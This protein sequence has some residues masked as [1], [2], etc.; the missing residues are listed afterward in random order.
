MAIRTLSAI[1]NL[2]R[3][4]TASKAGII[5][6]PPVP[7]PDVPDTPGLYDP[8]YVYNLYDISGDEPVLYQANVN[9]NTY[10][11]NHYINTYSL[12][13]RD[14]DFKAR[15]SMGLCISNAGQLFCIIPTV[16]DGE[17]VSVDN[18]PRLVDANTDWTYVS[19]FSTRGLAIRDGHVYYINYDSDEDEFNLA[20]VGTGFPDYVQASIGFMTPSFIRRSAS[21]YWST[22]NQ[23]FKYIDISNCRKI[24]GMPS[25]RNILYEDYDGYTHVCSLTEKYYEG[26]VIIIGYSVN[27]ILTGN[28]SN[29]IIAVSGTNIALFADGTLYKNASRYGR[30]SD[31]YQL[32]DDPQY[33]I[34]RE[35]P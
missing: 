21:I 12:A 9:P 15:A 24:I 34:R 33:A 8:D 11:Q 23:T 16:E 20:Q 3:Y 32:T 5:Y 18:S 28:A 22:D 17:V 19:S 30:L 4:R 26:T 13:S 6:C 2:R 10:R 31:W 7:S 27:N 35:N 14:G 1:A 25:R 29:P